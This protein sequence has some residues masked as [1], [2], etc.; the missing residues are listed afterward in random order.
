MSF[1]FVSS[2][3]VN[4]YV[5]A[6]VCTWWFGGIFQFPAQWTLSLWQNSPTVSKELHLPQQ[7]A[8]RN[9]TMVPPRSADLYCS[10]NNHTTNN[11][12]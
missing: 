11:I 8:K 5:I 6:A 9:V 12:L 4:L 3:F 2:T 10:L 1:P 7:A